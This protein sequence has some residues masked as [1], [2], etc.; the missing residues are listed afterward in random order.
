MSYRLEAFFSLTKN[1]SNELIADLIKK[2][3]DEIGG[4]TPYQ[5]KDIFKIWL[6]KRHV[7]E[8]AQE[9]LLSYKYFLELYELFPETCIKM[10]SLFKEIGYWKDIFLIWE[11]INDMKI[12]DNVR[13]NKYNKLIESFRD[14][15]LS[16][17]KL[18]LRTLKSHI[19]PNNLGDLDNDM[20]RDILK[21][22][23]D[24]N[25]SY[26]GK[27]CIREKSTLNKK[28]YWFIKNDDSLIKQSHVSYMI[29]G[30]LKIKDSNGNCEYPSNKSVPLKTKKMYRE[31]N[32]KLNVVLNTPELMM[33]SKQFN[34]IEPTELPY[35]FKK[36]NLLALMNEN[37]NKEVM[38]NERI[39]LRN[40]MMDY[41]NNNVFIDTKNSILES[42][43]E[44]FNNVMNK[45]IYNDLE[46]ILKLS[47]ETN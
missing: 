22:T 33:C 24:L 43:E 15:I 40:R 23:G 28:L 9:K 14:C 4:D 31:L 5:L 30:A 47:N 8:G 39:H 25:I 10:V 34:L 3:I 1:S 44:I 27:Y 18:D 20:L 2:M 35:L 37:N 7:R 42:K 29:R 38:S 17:R 19:Y 45:N 36:K 11:I 13:Y 21:S 12:S 6:Y 41:I 46:T 26:V 16:Q 32:A